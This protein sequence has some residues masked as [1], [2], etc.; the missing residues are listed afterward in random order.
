MYVCLSLQ[1]QDCRAQGPLPLL[2]LLLLLLLSR[3]EYVCECG[4]QKKEQVVLTGLTGGD[5]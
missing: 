3:G 2:Q 4:V 1:V 5:N